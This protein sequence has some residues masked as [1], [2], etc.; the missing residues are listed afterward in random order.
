MTS[1]SR[2]QRKLIYSVLVSLDGFIN[3]PNGEL[4]WHVV[5]DEF[6][7]F[8]NDLQLGV[9]TSLFGRKM[10]QTMTYWDTADQNETLSSDELAF[11]DQWNQQ[12]RIIFSSTLEA[13]SGNARLAQG[14]LEE[15]IRTL[16]EQDGK[17]IEI[18]GAALA[19]HAINLGLVD[20]FHLFVQPVLVGNGTSAFQEVT[21]RPRLYLADYHVF[22]SG[23][24]FHRYLRTD[25]PDSTR[26]IDDTP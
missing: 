13:V 5:D 2:T 20:E 25:T 9:D 18:G 12:E 6:L 3:G 11:A 19:S 17:N 7:Q 1:D 24:V 14:S 8:V 22:R 15:E 21:S 4:D 23:V 16:K 26:E 10:Y